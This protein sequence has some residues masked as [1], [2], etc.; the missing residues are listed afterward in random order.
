[1]NKILNKIPIILGLVIIGTVLVFVIPSTLD[2]QKQDR[3]VTYQVNF[4]SS[5]PDGIDGRFFVK[6]GDNW[7]LYAQLQYHPFWLDVGKIEYTREMVFKQVPD[8]THLAIQYWTTTDDFEIVDIA[9][10]GNFTT[11]FDIDRDGK[12]DFVYIKQVKWDDSNPRSQWEFRTNSISASVEVK[13][14]KSPIESMKIDV[15]TIIDI[16]K[17]YPD[18]LTDEEVDILLSHTIGKG[19]GMIDHEVDE[20]AQ[21]IM[22]KVL[23][24]LTENE[25]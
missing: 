10:D 19:Y 13:P 8:I 14:I 1:M 3:F 16:E 17:N 11:S 22:W 20:E 23:D 4:V 24:H 6:K 18:L 21:K 12:E 2:A 5:H 25:N 15:Q 7:M 9:G